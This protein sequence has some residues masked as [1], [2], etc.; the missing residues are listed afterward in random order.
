MGLLRKRG[1]VVNQFPGARTDW[2]GLGHAEPF[3][4]FIPPDEKESVKATALA[5][6]FIM[7][8]HGI[9]RYINGQPYI[10]PAVPMLIKPEK[11][12]MTD[13]LI[14][15]M[16]TLFSGM[17]D[18]GYR[19]GGMLFNKDGRTGDLPPRFS[20]FVQEGSCYTPFW[21]MVERKAGQHVITNTMWPLHPETPRLERSLLQ[22]QNPLTKGKPRTIPF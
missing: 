5:L 17:D 11:E 8:P 20:V 13:G 14:T 1:G 4:I 3:G 18:H 15:T 22:W 6:K 16:A 12:M 19:N 21:N 9:V 10:S 7:E 2:Q